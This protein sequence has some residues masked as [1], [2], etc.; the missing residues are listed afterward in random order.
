MKYPVA[1]CLATMTLGTASAAEMPALQI[2]SFDVDPAMTTAGKPVKLRWSVVGARSISVSGLSA[3]PKDGAVVLPSA[4]TT[5]VLTAVGADGQV[6]SAQV[7]VEVR[8]G[9]HLASVSV[10]PQHPGTA[11][12]PGFIGISHEWAQAPLL[13]GD[14]S[15][16]VNAPYRQLLKNLIAYGNGPLNIRVGAN[17]TDRTHEFTAEMMRPLKELAQAVDTRWTLGVN[18]GAG[19]VGLA[20]RQAK[21][22]VSE[23]PQ[24]SIETIEVGNE[25]N[26]YAGRKGHRAAGYD[27]AQYQEDFSK[28]RSALVPLLPNGVKLM[29]PSYAGSRLDYLNEF[30][31]EAN[32]RQFLE[33]EGRYLGAFS[34]HVYAGFNGTGSVLPSGMLLAEAASDVGPYVLKPYIAL[35]NAYHV[36]FRIAEMNAIA[37]GGRAGVSDAF[38]AAL[39]IMDTMFEYARMGASGVNLHTN[40]DNDYA[41]FKFH[42]PASQ[43][44]VYGP[45][46]SHAPEDGS[47]MP[48]PVRAAWQ[49]FAEEDQGRDAY[50]VKRVM[51][52][53]YGLLQFAQATPHQAH[54]LPVK[55][56][57]DA[58]LKVWATQDPKDQSLRILVIN[59]S[60]TDGTVD[61]N[62]PV[63]GDAVVTRLMAPGYQAR[64]GISIGGQTFDGTRDGKPLG[65]TYGETVKPENGNYHLAIGAASALLLTI[66]PAT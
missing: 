54:L 31:T 21:V 28:W 57:T 9:Q 1:C 52:I 51:P 16:A 66:R 34:Q 18:V 46:G 26:H 27:F 61:L 48:K 45:G 58:N 59:K 2:Q 56:A 63:A 30:L 6:A 53:Y 55:R 8:G 35:S 19:D 23:M 60:V 11:I 4:S 37:R 25:P 39:W 50:A 47:T 5:Y 36:P 3:A 41:A 20:V 7:R 17:S 22:L 40:N 10:D 13:M 24:G 42:A 62:L 12:P 33:R 65:T 44:A 64:E 38:E 29:G 43:Y 15:T 49:S 14:S 32:A